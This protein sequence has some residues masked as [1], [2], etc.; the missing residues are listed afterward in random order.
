MH[1][2]DAGVQAARCTEP[3][4]VSER[5]GVLEVGR[6][7]EPMPSEVPLPSVLTKGKV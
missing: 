6:A 4:G 5:H 7:T 2:G 3:Q 1:G